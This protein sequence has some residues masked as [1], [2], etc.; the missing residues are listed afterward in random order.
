MVDVT[1]K[2]NLENFGQFTPLRWLIQEMKAHLL[3]KLY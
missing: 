1:P 2:S 3:A